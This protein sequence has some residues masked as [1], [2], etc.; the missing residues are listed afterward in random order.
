M[1]KESHKTE[2]RQNFSKPRKRLG[3]QNPGKG[4]NNPST[5]SGK[6]L[7]GTTLPQLQTFKKDDKKGCLKNQ[8]GAEE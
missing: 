4:Q 7:G 2:Q 3:R 5:R 8:K 6:K 1:E